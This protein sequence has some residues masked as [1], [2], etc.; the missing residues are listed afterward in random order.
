ME[1][2]FEHKTVNRLL[3]KLLAMTQNDFVFKTSD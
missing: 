3:T 1:Q 2:L